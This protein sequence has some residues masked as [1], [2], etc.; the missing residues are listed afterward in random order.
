MQGVLQMWLH[1]FEASSPGTLPTD[2]KI[3]VKTCNSEEVHL[4]N[5]SLYLVLVKNCTGADC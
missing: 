5:A 4:E 2:S 3:D 1:E